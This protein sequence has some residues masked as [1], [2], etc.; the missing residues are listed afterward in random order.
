MT[1]MVSNKLWFPYHV[2]FLNLV[3]FI[4]IYIKCVVNQSWINKRYRRI[5]R[6]REIYLLNI[7]TEYFKFLNRLYNITWFGAA[8]A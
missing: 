5:C 4:R 6:H 3:F 8:Y 1:E 2:L 7:F